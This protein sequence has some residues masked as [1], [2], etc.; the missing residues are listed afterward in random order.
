MLVT[1]KFESVVS[2]PSC[3]DA[4]TAVSKV[5][6]KGEHSTTTFELPSPN[7]SFRS[8]L[9]LTQLCRASLQ[10]MHPCPPS[11]PCSMQ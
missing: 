7:L 4:R 10:G 9:Q 8:F 11:T 6:V 2:T 3:W 5:L 1:W